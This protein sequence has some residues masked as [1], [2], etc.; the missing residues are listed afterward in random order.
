M[1]KAIPADVLRHLSFALVGGFFGAHAI[2]GPGGIFG[3][4]QTVNL[5]ET[6][7]SAIRGDF[8]SLGLHLAAL[9]FY[10]VGVMAAVLLREKFH[11][12]TARISPLLSAVC[13]FWLGLLPFGL[14]PAIYLYPIF[15]AMSFQWTAFTG[16]RGYV[17]ST[18]FSTNNVKQASIGLARYISDGQ[19]RHLRRTGFFCLTLITF[20]VGAAIGALSVHILPRFAAWLALPLIALSYAAVLR[21]EH[22]SCSETADAADRGEDSP[23]A[24][25]IPPVNI[26]DI[27][28]CL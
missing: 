1:K 26:G 18:I 20:H 23:P 6:L 15:L 7:F 9:A 11:R 22:V 8:V 14:H 24:S 16:A 10:V 4:A 19:R 2:L 25:C 13:A 5:L 28:D 21:E 17:S 3:N 27:E 12:D